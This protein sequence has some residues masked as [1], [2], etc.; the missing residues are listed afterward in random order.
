MKAKED[1]L[2]KRHENDLVKINLFRELMKMNL[3]KHIL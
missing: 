3:K 2:I 1:E